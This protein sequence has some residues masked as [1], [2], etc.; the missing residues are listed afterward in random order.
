VLDGYD[1]YLYIVDED[2]GAYR[3]K[4]VTLEFFPGPNHVTSM[5]CEDERPEN[6]LFLSSGV[7]GGCAPLSIDAIRALQTNSGGGYEPP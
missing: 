3:P 2:M 6:A 5:A 1:A 7:T 4:W